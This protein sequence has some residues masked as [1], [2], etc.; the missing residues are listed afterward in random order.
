MKGNMRMY[1]NNLGTDEFAN[2]LPPWASNKFWVDYHN[3]VKNMHKELKKSISEISKKIIEKELG[4]DNLDDE[5][6]HIYN[7]MKK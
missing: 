5:I 7:M 2:T 3:A 4:I 1:I 6:S